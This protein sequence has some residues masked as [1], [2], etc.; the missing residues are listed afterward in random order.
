MPESQHFSGWAEGGGEA[1]ERGNMPRST[2]PTPRRA[3]TLPP[4]SNQP[5]HACTQKRGTYTSPRMRA[6]RVLAPAKENAEKGMLQWGRK[7]A[8]WGRGGPP[9]TEGGRQGGR[10]PGGLRPDN[11]KDGERGSPRRSGCAWPGCTLP[12]FLPGHAWSPGAPRVGRERLRGSC[13]CLGAGLGGRD[14]QEGGSRQHG[15]EESEKGVQMAGAVEGGGSTQD[16][17]GVSWRVPNLDREL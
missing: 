11:N 12:L 16:N 8:G 5:A 17:S 4:R 3:A 13:L 1:L 6:Q 14:R 2:P 9:R 15:A 10:K 7:P